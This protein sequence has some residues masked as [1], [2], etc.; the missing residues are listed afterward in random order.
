MNKNFSSLLNKKPKKQNNKKRID[1]IR[2]SN[3]ISNTPTTGIK[4]H[5]AAPPLIER[6]KTMQVEKYEGSI[7][8]K[9]D[10]GI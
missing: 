10:Q 4:K 1:T 8:D 3:E 7:A 6:R 9:I 5:V 2:E